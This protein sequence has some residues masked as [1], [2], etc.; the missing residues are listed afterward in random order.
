M[1][2]YLVSSSQSVRLGYQPNSFG[3]FWKYF[4]L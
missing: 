3:V 4:P 2:A 1:V